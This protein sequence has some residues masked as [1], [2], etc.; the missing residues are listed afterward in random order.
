MQSNIKYIE[1]AI[2][3]I[4][5]VASNIYEFSQVIIDGENGFLASTEDEWYEKI[6]QLILNPTLR[7]NMAQNAFR[8]CEALYRKEKQ[9]ELFKEILNNELVETTETQENKLKV[10]Q[11]NLYYGINSFGGAT[12]VVEN[13]AKEMYALSEKQIEVN[14]FTTHSGDEAGVGALRKYD[15]EGIPVYSCSANVNEGTSIDDPTIDHVFW[16]VI[17]T[18]KPDIVHFHAVQG[19]G[20]GLSKICRE[21]HIPYVMTLHDRWPYCPKLFMVDEKGEDCTKYGTSVDVCEHQCHFNADWI[22]TRRNKLYEMLRGASQ[23]YVPSFH[24]KAELEKLFPDFTMIVNI[25][26]G[27]KIFRENQ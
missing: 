21:Q 1:A 26:T 16:D 20:C 2:L 9:K 3:K 8:S 18:V 19:F 15:F 22:A 4:P 12:I 25:K 6:R 5:S 14:V 23:L 24:A 13:L 11:V 17:Q 27:L 7:K 10:L